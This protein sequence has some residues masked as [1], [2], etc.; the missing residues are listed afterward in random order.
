MWAFS[1]LEDPMRLHLERLAVDTLNEML[2]ILIGEDVGGLPHEGCPLYKYKNKEDL[3]RMMSRFDQW[4][5]LLE[6]H[7]AHRDN[8]VLV[9]PVL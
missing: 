9:T 3:V 5:L 1:G 6:G 8:P 2:Q 4:G 7:N